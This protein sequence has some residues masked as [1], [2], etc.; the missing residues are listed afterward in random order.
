MMMRLSFWLVISSVSV[1]RISSKCM[2]LSKMESISDPDRQRTI[3]PGRAGFLASRSNL[4]ACII[5]YE[6]FSC[7][8]SRIPMIT[9]R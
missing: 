9:T 6:I 8:W 7:G 3:R 1:S 2:T 5:I 4:A